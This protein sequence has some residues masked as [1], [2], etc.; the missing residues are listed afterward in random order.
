[1]PNERT[2]M[3]LIK[4]QNA[5]GE[6]LKAVQG[7]M[8]KVSEAATK[9][10]EKTEK[11]FMQGIRG[12][13]AFVRQI[14]SIY[15]VIGAIVVGM[16]YKLAQP[17]NEYER[18]LLKMQS[19]AGLTAKDISQIGEVF[20]KQGKGIGLGTLALANGTRDVS[21]ATSLYIGIQET[22]VSLYNKLLP[23]MEVQEDVA[24]RL[25]IGINELWSAMGNQEPLK[26]WDAFHGKINTLKEAYILFGDKA[27]AIMEILSKTRE[28]LVKDNEIMAEAAK[29]TEEAAKRI[30]PYNTAIK[31]M[32]EAWLTARGTIAPFFAALLIGFSATLPLMKE[33]AESARKSFAEVGHDIGDF[34][35]NFGKGKGAVFN[36]PWEGGIEGISPPAA[37]T[38]SPTVPGVLPPEE[39][40]KERV[41]AA[42]AELKQQES[43]VTEGVGENITELIT[44]VWDSTHTIGETVRIIGNGVV[45]IVTKLKQIE[46]QM[47]ADRAKIEAQLGN[48]NG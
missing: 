35:R 8:G 15:Y 21:Q 30:E 2:V 17:I 39:I 48:I 25:G 14:R 47:N 29:K 34:F 22:L 44:T 26:I 41:A 20:E 27:W 37:V 4:A 23:K 1:M 28:E 43:Y 38:P 13:F 12:A 36:I 40:S 7:D 46:A 24:A 10:G 5:T 18:A 19:T 9:M 31:D 6:A 45:D 33:L 32:G 3:L 42:V 11:G 16:I